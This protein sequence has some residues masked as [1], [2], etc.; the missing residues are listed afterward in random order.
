MSSLYLASADAR[1][2]R[3]SDVAKFPEKGPLRHLC[4][5]SAPVPSLHLAH[6]D[7]SAPNFELAALYCLRV[8]VKT[9]L[10]HLLFSVDDDRVGSPR[11][12]TLRSFLYDRQ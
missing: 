2:A 1:V 6:S 10:S 8:G 12:S 3:C 5:L 9:S 4:P 11:F 7:F